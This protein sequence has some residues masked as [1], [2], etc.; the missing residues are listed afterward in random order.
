[1]HRYRRVVRLN[2]KGQK[3]STFRRGRKARGMRKRRTATFLVAAACL[4]STLS[5]TPAAGAEPT[6]PERLIVFSYLLPSTPGDIYVVRPDG[7][8][9]LNLTDSPWHDTMPAWS[10]DGSKIAFI[11]NRDGTDPAIGKWDVFVMDADGTDARNI[12]QT[13]D[14]DERVPTWSADATALLF[15]RGSSIYARE[16]ASGEER[17][18]GG[19]GNPAPS[20][21]GRLIAFDTGFGDGAEN[22]LLLMR[23]DGSRVRNFR[24]DDW[25]DRDPDWSPASTHIAW[26]RDDSLA[27]ARLGRRG[28]RT[29]EPAKDGVRFEYPTWS[30][31]G[32][33]LAVVH[34]GQIYLV[35]RRDGQL[36][37]V[38][39]MAGGGFV[40]YPDWR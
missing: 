20:P 23:T 24:S 33:R 37:Q 8:D 15:E 17:K 1:M 28:V 3:G 6:A 39:S 12:T 34:E 22:A 32:R 10:P 26:S 11:S 14:A 30:P 2:S 16:L 18:I 5:M 21:D 38:T 19:G 25:D 29:I 13:D 36:R 31:S 27:I 9:L 35:R 40:G 4:A 7:S